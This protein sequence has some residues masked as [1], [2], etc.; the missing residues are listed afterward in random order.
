MDPAEQQ[1][2]GC[3]ALEQGCPELLSQTNLSKLEQ[4]KVKQHRPIT[5]ADD[6]VGDSGHSLPYFEKIV[7]KIP[8]ETHRPPLAS[9]SIYTL[10]GWFARLFPVP[11]RE[12]LQSSFFRSI[13]RNTGKKGH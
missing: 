2:A 12:K 9:G 7:I 11:G 13:A 4:I 5:P 8:T 6:P 10:K 1:P 3:T